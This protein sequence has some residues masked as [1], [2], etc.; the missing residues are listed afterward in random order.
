MIGRFVFAS[1][2]IALLAPVMAGPA[3]AADAEPFNGEKLFATTCGWCHQSGGR[4]AG[5]GPK[6][7]GTTRSDE[8]II[9]RIK[10]GKQGAMPAFAG[11]L[12]DAKI[13]GIL[14]YIRNLKD[15]AN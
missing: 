10:N 7:A 3:R 1:M 4:V 11:T 15:D 5:R 2:V 14:K 12:D 6:L 9:E 13:Q 8:F